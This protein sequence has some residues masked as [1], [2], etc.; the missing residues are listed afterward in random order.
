MCKGFE[1][2]ELWL[3]EATAI[4][5]KNRVGPGLEW[6]LLS[7]LLGPT[8]RGTWWKSKSRWCRNLVPGDLTRKG[9]SGAA[10]VQVPITQQRTSLL[11]SSIIG[12]TVDNNTL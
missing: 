1:E 12:D 11:F 3:R 10:G 6:R 5:S 2:I 4:M 7:S 9:R 8:P